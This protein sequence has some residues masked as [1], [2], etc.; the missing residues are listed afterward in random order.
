MLFWKMLLLIGI[1]EERGTGGRLSMQPWKWRGRAMPI[2]Y[3]CLVLAQTQMCTNSMKA[4]VLK[5]GGKR[6]MLLST[7][8]LTD[9]AVSYCG[10]NAILMV[11]WPEGS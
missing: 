2:R 4:A 5:E 11:I 6:D 9:A 3:C 1:I 10:L 7:R 8:P